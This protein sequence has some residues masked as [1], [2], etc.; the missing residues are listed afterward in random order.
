MR[1]RKLVPTLAGVALVFGGLAGVGL[2]QAPAALA[3]SC[4]SGYQAKLYNQS[5]TYAQDEEG[6][7]VGSSSKDA[8]SVCS[9]F[10]GTQGFP[11]LES[12]TT[13]E[14]LTWS[15][16]SSNEEGHL[17]DSPC[18]AHPESQTWLPGPAGSEI[19]N[20]Y[21]GECLGGTG[22]SEGS[23]LYVYSCAPGGNDE[24]QNWYGPVPF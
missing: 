8:T 18:G 24:N 4:A 13:G 9:V 16:P 15:S 22:G 6:I 3:A 5:G 21:S 11:Y 1:F 17:Y 12:M 20:Y 23:P 10:D 2:A 14:C 19:E 7:W